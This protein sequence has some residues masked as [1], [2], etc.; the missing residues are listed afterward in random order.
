MSRLTWLGSFSGPHTISRSGS[1]VYPYQSFVPGHVF[2]TRD[3]LGSGQ[4]VAE[5]HIGNSDRPY[6]GSEPRA[7]LESPHYFG[8]GSDY[9]VSVPVLIPR[10]F[11]TMTSHGWFQVAEIYGQPYGG[12]PTIGLDLISAGG[13]NRLVLERDATHNYDKPWV[14]PPLDGRWHTITIHVKMSTNR[15]VGFVQLW[16]DGVARDLRGEDSSTDKRLYYATLV[17]GLNWDGAHP[18]MLDVNSYRCHGC[19]PGTVTLYHAAPAIGHS[20]GSVRQAAVG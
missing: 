18:D 11:P 10:G 9:Y 19:Y 2:A 12:S 16:Y 7:D 8:P 14:G 6:P 5:Y 13:S 15:R 20:S 17:R 4:M 3:P 1:T